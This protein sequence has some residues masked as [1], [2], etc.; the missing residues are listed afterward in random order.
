MRVL[1]CKIGYMKYYKGVNENDPIYNGGEYI[2][3]YGDGGETYNFD[4]VKLEDNLEYCL[5]FV[6]TKSHKNS[7]SSERTHNQLHIEKIINSND[8]E[9]DSIDEVLVVW[10]AVKP[11]IGLRVVGW[12][13]NATIYRDYIEYK[14]DG[15]FI[16]EANI[17]AEKE[18]CVLLP[19]NEVNRYIWSAPASK[20]QGYGFGQSLVWYP[21]EK[22][23]EELLNQI[24]MYNGKNYIDMNH[25]IDPNRIEKIK[26]F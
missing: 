7:N 9:I 6:E 1:F 18:N 3:K 20:K 23:V 2:K 26:I 14:F 17:I 12:Y 21:N 4:A 11:D 25:E 19:H 10:C 8:T 13:K 15:G 16:Q 24:V 5:G 22:D